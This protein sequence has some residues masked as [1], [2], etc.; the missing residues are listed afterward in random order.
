MKYE[1][2]DINKKIERIRKA[3]KCSEPDRIPLHDF[4]WD[5]FIK[6][7]KKAGT[8]CLYEYVMHTMDVPF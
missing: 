4:F 1:L 8:M 5:E 2:S 7:W 3:L 6:R